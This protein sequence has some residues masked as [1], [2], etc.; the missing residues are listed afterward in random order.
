M[1]IPFRITYIPQDNQWGP[2]DADIRNMARFGHDGVTPRSEIVNNLFYAIDQNYPG[3]YEI[4]DAVTLA[5]AKAESFAKINQR[6]LEI[7]ESGFEYQMLR[8]PCTQL[9][10]IR[11][12]GMHAFREQIAYPLSLS[13]IDEM[14]TVDM[15]SATDVLYF[16]G[17]CVAH[18]RAATDS[19][20]SLKNTVRSVTDQTA[21]DFFEDT[22]TV[23]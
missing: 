9:A 21:L 23:P 16:C 22:R 20:M 14:A 5:D 15:T 7:V 10:Q 11:Y 4:D 17:S 12:L 19:G 8:F 3:V 2:F 13:T 1:T 18:V 6:T